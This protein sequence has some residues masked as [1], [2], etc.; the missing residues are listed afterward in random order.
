MPIFKYNMSKNT[1]YEQACN[2]VAGF[3]SMSE[4]FTRKL[5]IDG[6]SKSTHENYLRQMAMHYKESPLELEIDQLEEYLYHLIQNDSD[7]LNSFKPAYRT[8]QASGVWPAYVP[9]VRQR[10]PS[11]FPAIDQQAKQA[12]GCALCL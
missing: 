5:V 1:I 12:T 10:R 4:E 2:Q 8:R 3:R 11:A 6:R 7:S 9:P